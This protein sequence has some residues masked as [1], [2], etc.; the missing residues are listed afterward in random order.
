MG[1]LRGLRTPYSRGQF[2]WFQQYLSAQP[3]GSAFM[4]NTDYNFQPNRSW[5]II[6][7]QGRDRRRRARMCNAAA[8]SIE[9]RHRW[10]LLNYILPVFTA[11]PIT[12]LFS[13]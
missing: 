11:K 5:Q 10:Q 6:G 1:P 4:K 8:G 12:S 13:R 9:S 7:Q 3:T 2:E